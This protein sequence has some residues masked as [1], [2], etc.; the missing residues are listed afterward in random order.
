MGAG[1]TLPTMSVIRQKKMA[2]ANFSEVSAELK[3]VIDSINRIFTFDAT[4]APAA[5]D[6][7]KIWVFR[8][9][10]TERLYYKSAL[11]GTWRGPL[12]LT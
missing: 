3:N 10:S 9:G 12:N 5:N 11:S 2:H 8:D 6:D 4:R 1:D 7:G